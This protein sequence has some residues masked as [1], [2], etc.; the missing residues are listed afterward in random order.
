MVCDLLRVLTLLLTGSIILKCVAYNPSTSWRNNDAFAALKEDG[1]VQAWGHSDY[2]GSTSTTLA[3]VRT[4]F[5][6]TRYYS[7]STSMHHYPCP[8]RYYGSGMPDC[9]ACPSDVPD[10]KKNN[11]S[12]GIRSVQGS[13]ILCDQPTFSE[14]GKT[15]A[16]ACAEGYTY[17]PPTF[18]DSTQSGCRMCHGAG[19][20]YNSTSKSCAL[21]PKGYYSE[22]GNILTCSICPSGKYADKTGAGGC[23][24]CDTDYTSLNGSTSKSQCFRICVAGRYAPF[25]TKDECRTCERGKYSDAMAFECTTCLPGSISQS[26]SQNCTLCVPGKFQEK[27]DRFECDP[28]PQ[29]TYSTIYGATNCTVC[30]S[31]P[32]ETG[33]NKTTGNTVCINKAL[34]EPCPDGE[35][36]NTTAGTC[37]ACDKGKY[38]RGDTCKP[39]EAGTYGASEGLSECTPCPPGTYSATT[40]ATSNDTCK[41]CHTRTYNSFPGATVTHAAALNGHADCLRMLIAAKADLQKTRPSTGEAPLHSAALSGHSSKQITMEGTM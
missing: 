1:T 9:S 29:D 32:E 31:E 34:Y 22:E 36:K 24:T 23:S 20:F 7:D 30:P 37:V 26:N 8:N 5:G 12:L 28:C 40:G 17:Y 35:I 38:Q 41:E 16:D 3:N 39:C 14:D 15:C 2:G 13:C 11:F 25:G 19:K 10:S 4:I 27:S 18:Y 33:T 6:S 21:C